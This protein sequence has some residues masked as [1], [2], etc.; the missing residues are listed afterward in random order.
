MVEMPKEHRGNVWGE[1][2]V[3]ESDLH[4]MTGREGMS[5]GEIQNGSDRGHPRSEPEPQSAQF[6][7][8]KGANGTCGLFHTTTPSLR[9]SCRPY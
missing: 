3:S 9:K 4:G 8:L 1:R 2:T 6:V 7:G 5:V